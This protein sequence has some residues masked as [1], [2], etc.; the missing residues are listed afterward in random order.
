MDT[1]ALQAVALAASNDLRR[2]SAR[3][4]HSAFEFDRD[5]VFS[6]LNNGIAAANALLPDDLKVEP[7]PVPPSPTRSTRR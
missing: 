2:V 6:Q 7:L 3:H 5:L 1:L 4:A